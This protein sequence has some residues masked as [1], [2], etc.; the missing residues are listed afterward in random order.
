[1]NYRRIY[2][3]HYGPIPVDEF[4]RSYEIHHIDGNRKNNDIS[5]LKAVS[6]QEHYNIH[7]SQED[8]G[9]CIKIAQ[10]MKLMPEEISKLVSRQQ[11]ERVSK[12]IHH[13]LGGESQKIHMRRLVLEGTH[14]FCDSEVQSKINKLRYKN[15]TGNFTSELSKRVARERIENGTHHFVGKNNPVY[16]QLAEG[17]H[18]FSNRKHEIK[19]C[20][21]C[22]IAMT[23]PNFVRW[24]HGE[25]CKKEPKL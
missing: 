15:G 11:R 22:M 5:N 9:A 25:N 8:W 10:K 6:I 17:R 12:G 2:K 23:V 14:H 3:K 20:P 24:G 7:Y 21:I 13:W 19:T 18:P 16:K 1:M 4:G